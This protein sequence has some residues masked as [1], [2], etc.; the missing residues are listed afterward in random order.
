MAMLVLAS[1]SVARANM[2]RAA[3]VEIEVDPV[4]GE[5][6]VIELVGTP[7]DFDRRS[8]E[9]PGPDGK[10]RSRVYSS[11]IGQ[12][13]ARVDGLRVVHEVDESWMCVRAVV[14]SSAS[15]AD[16][17]F[18]GETKAAWTQP[19]RAPGNSPLLNE[20]TVA[21]SPRGSSDASVGSGASG[22]RSSHS[23]SSSRTGTSL[24]E[25]TR[26]SASRSDADMVSPVGLW[27]VGIT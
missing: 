5:E 24:S 19:V 9:R 25:T 11:D 22:D 13:I 4:P 27:N 12:V 16:P 14:R 7:V 18:E 21:V 10:R 6:Y 8:T 23:N 20:R 2:L 26:M 15:V 1:G 3:G 17:S